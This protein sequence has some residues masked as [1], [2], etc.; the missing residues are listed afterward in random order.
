M[1]T[2]FAIV[3]NSL[4]WTAKKTGL[5]YNEINIIVYY[6]AIPLTWTVM[7]DFIIALPILTPILLLGWT[8]QYFRKR[9][10]FRM[11]CDWAFQDSVEFLLWFKRIGWNYTVASVII[12]IVVP[13]IIYVILIAGL[14]CK[15]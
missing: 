6:L 14:I 9:K 7:A 13:L 15:S 2:V 10:F 12:C 1:E 5:T 3:A 8:V 4:L 11:W